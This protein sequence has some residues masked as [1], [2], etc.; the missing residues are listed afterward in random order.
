[1]LVAASS[2]AWTRSSRQTGGASAPSATSRTSARIFVRLSRSAAT[3]IPAT[4]RHPREVRGR[5]LDEPSGALATGE[6]AVAHDD[7]AAR[8]H[9]LRRALDLATLVAGVVDVHVVGA[10]RDRVPARWVV[11]HDV[12]VRADRDR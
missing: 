11:D 8:Q 7:R 6:L 9:D 2:T 1:M 3:V 5:A 4:S 10:R 12:R